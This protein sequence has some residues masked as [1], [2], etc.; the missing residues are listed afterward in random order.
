MNDMP[1]RRPSPFAQPAN[2]GDAFVP[3]PRD[4][5]ADIYAFNGSEAHQYLVDSV[6]RLQ[7]SEQRQ[8]AAQK[9]FPQG[10]TAFQSFM[11]FVQMKADEGRFA[12]ADRQRRLKD[13]YI[14]DFEAK[15]SARRELDERKIARLAEADADAVASFADSMVLDTD[16]LDTIPVPDPLIEN[17]LDLN[18]TARLYGESGSKKSFVTLDMAACIATGLPWHGN[19]VTQ[20]NVVY[21]VAEGSTGIM[22]RVRAWE[23]EHGRKMTG[24]HFVTEAIQIGDPEQMRTLIGYAKLVNAGMVIFDTQARC[25]VGI[26]ENSNTDMGRIVAALDSLRQQTGA[27]VMLVHHKGK[28]AQDA[29]GASAMKGAMDAEFEVGCEGKGMKVTFKTTKRKDGEEQPTLNLRLAEHLI[30]TTRGEETSL[31]VCEYAT[32]GELIPGSEDD[33]VTERHCT[34]R[35]LTV[36]EDVARYDVVSSVQVARDIDLARNRTS[37][38]LSQLRKMQC[39][40]QVGPANSPKYRVTEIGWTT[41]SRNSMTVGYHEV[42]PLDADG[43]SAA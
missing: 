29:R 35:Q 41:L 17:F 28:N 24:V 19:T 40:E 37:E 5:A 9:L 26:D 13:D 14:L 20:R 2:D 43:D 39:V 38:A 21:V 42:A 6:A 8:E 1:F 27:C 4:G 34:P 32:V 16:T 15:E 31:S 23:R 18:C 7:T 30:T 22:R 25:T 33:I 11:A 12:A 36:L 10:G 3:G